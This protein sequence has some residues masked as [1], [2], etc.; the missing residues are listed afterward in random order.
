MNLR[1]TAQGYRYLAVR[2]GSKGIIAVSNIKVLIGDGLKLASRVVGRSELAVAFR[3]IFSSTNA[4]A[5]ETSS[6]NPQVARAGVDEKGIGFTFNFDIYIP[7]GA[8]EAC[9]T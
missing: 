1:Y 8:L 3:K 9:Q 7:C 6:G 2:P 4:D 5:L